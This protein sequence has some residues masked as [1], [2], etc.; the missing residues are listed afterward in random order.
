MD[1][2]LRP[3]CA[4]ARADAY[5]FLAPFL[6]YDAPTVRPQSGGWA[7]PKIPKIILLNLLNQVGI[8]AFNA[9][10]VLEFDLPASRRSGFETLAYSYRLM[11]GF[12]PRDYRSDLRAMSEP[13]LVM[14]GTDDEAF[15][16]DEFMPIFSKLAPQA[17]VELVP[18]VAHLELVTAPQVQ[19][20]VVSWVRELSAR[21][22]TRDHG[23]TM[24]DR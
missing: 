13:A 21:R 19:D 16:S 20:A 18:G 9:A 7:H 4:A 24:S 10:T 6:Q 23:K 12:A 17:R 15:Y 22:L 5:L 8:T 11:N 14:V 2:A 1:A 3:G